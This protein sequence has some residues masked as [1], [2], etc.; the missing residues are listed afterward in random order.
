MLLHIEEHLLPALL[1]SFTSGAC[2]SDV[3]TARAAR[4]HLEELLG[5]GADPSAPDYDGR[6]TLHVAASAG[7]AM[8][9]SLHLQPCEGLIP[10]RSQCPSLP[11]AWCC[12]W[13]QVRLLLQHGVN[14]TCIDRFGNTPL[15]DAVTHGRP[16]VV[17]LLV[18]RGARLTSD[19]RAAGVCVPARIGAHDVFSSRRSNIIGTMHGLRVTHDVSFSPRVRFSER[20]PLPSPLPAILRPLPQLPCVLQQLETTWMLFD[21][22]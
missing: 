20:H 4:G 12:V 19:P 10:N 21:C 3:A 13:R 8:M 17:E 22:C 2:C 9:V 15:W 18:R 11:R 7:N 1:C 16:A 6:T 5:C 14:P